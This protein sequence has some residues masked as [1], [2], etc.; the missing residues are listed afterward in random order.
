V[1]RL[2]VVVRRFAVLRRRYPARAALVRRAAVVVDSPG[3]SVGALTGAIPM[4]DTRTGAGGCF[5]RGAAAAMPPGTLCSGWTYAWPSARAV[6]P[7]SLI[8]L[9]VL[10]ARP[11][12]VAAPT[13]GSTI[14]AMGATAF[15]ARPMSRP[16]RLIPFPSLLQKSPR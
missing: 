8:R 9:D 7:A 13:A 10:Y 1:R 15:A 6:R 14:P 5:T 2:V 11:T 4:P 12:S 3:A 16:T